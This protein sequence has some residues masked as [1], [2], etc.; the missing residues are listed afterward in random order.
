MSSYLES[1]ARERLRGLLDAGGLEEF[2]PAWEQVP[3]P[4]LAQLNLPVAADDGVVIG[5]GRLAG[6]TVFVAAQDGRFM[7]GAVSEVH[8]AKVIGLLRRAIAERPDAVLLLLDSGGVR[9]HEA[10]AGMIAVAEMLRAALDAR[11]AGIPVVTLIGGHNGAFGGMGLLARCANAVIISAQGRLSMSGPKVIETASGVAEFDAGDKALVWRTTGGRHRYLLGDCQAL[12]AD[13][14]AAF[15]Q[16]AI[17][18]IAATRG[19]TVELTLEGLEREQRLLSE[20]IDSFG[21]LSDPVEIWRALGIA[22][23]DAIPTLEIG[24]FATLADAHRLGAQP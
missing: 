13:S 5:R 22:E 6:A 4:H 19:R 20:R 15:R 18:A 24:H 16:A 21:Q 1:N 3:N 2:L 17:D 9:L 14:L 11:A 23:P 10:N 12:V 8:G 7:G